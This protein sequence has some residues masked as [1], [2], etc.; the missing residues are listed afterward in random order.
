LPREASA[1]CTDRQ[2]HG[3]LALAG[4]LPRKQQVRDVRARQDQDDRDCRHQDHERLSIRQ[5]E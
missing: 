2:P 4:A 5:A 3:E 1:S